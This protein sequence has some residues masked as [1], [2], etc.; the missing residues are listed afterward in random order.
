MLLCLCLARATNQGLPRHSREKERRS[1][2]TA[3]RREKK[4][5]RGGPGCGRA[6]RGRGPGKNEWRGR[7]GEGSC[8]T[9]W[10][11]A[12]HGPP[13]R[14]SPQ[15]RPR[16]GRKSRKRTTLGHSFPPMS[17]Y[18]YLTP[19]TTWG[20]GK[21]PG[22]VLCTTS[23][24]RAIRSNL[25]SFCLLRVREVPRAQALTFTN[26]TEKK[27]QRCGIPRPPCSSCDGFLESRRKK[28]TSVSSKS[29]TAQLN[30]PNTSAGL[31]DSIQ[32][33][34][35]SSALSLDFCSTTLG[36]LS[37]SPRITN[38]PLRMFPS[39]TDFFLCQVFMSAGERRLGSSRK[40][41]PS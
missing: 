36:H 11:G 40:I 5:R 14:G 23:G 37:W 32:H 27:F 28:I 30:P 38:R 7:C 1:W 24:I 34:F 8:K 3:S 18:R 12:C 13:C 4:S 16:E 19:A 22:T 10:F 25:Q 26:K 39:P 41:D 31:P 33:F 6:I 2:I 35:F 9:L 17:M 29:L 20:P 15:V 21:T